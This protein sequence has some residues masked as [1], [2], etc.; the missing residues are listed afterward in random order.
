LTECECEWYHHAGE[1]LFTCNGGGFLDN[2]TW[3]RGQAWALYG[4][5]MVYRYTHKP[6]HLATA[7]KVA[8][9]FVGRLSDAFPDHGEC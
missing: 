1:K 9:F 2:T 5:T 7:T 3:A 4:F 6:A 8:D